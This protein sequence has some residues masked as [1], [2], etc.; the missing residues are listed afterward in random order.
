[1]IFVKK[2][3]PPKV[4]STEHV[5]SLTKK[6]VSFFHEPMTKRRQSRFD[7]GTV[8]PSKELKSYLAVEFNSKCVYCESH[9]DVTELGDHES[10]RPRR[11]AKGINSEFSEDHYWWLA[12]EWQN[13]YYSCHTCNASKQSFF[14][15]EGKRCRIQAPYKE[16]LEERNLLIDPCNEDPERS[17]KYNRDG[18][19][20]PLNERAKITIDI[21]KLNRKQLVSLRRTALAML[22][23]S[24]KDIKRSRGLI[25][26]ITNNPKSERPYL[27]ILR[28]YL[29]EK[30]L[31]SPIQTSLA[32]ELDTNIEER[33]NVI[34]ESIEVRNFKAIEHLKARIFN[35]VIEESVTPTKYP[36]LMLLG[37]NGVGKSTFLQALTLALSGQKYIDA[38]GKAPS[39]ILR[40]GCEYGYVKVF[41]YGDKEPIE[42]RF[43]RTNEKIIC[44]IPEPLTYVL[45][46]GSTRLPPIGAMKPETSDGKVHALNL[47]RHDIALADASQW[48][49]EKYKS[50]EKSP[51]DKK[52]F[53]WVG[54]SIK[55]LLELGNNEKL[56]VRDDK[57]VITY[58]GRNHSVSLED[59]SDGYKSV[60]SLTVDVVKTL[61]SGKT[62]IDTA[63]GVVIIDEI[64][65][66]LHPKWRMRIVQSLRNVFPL[67]Q[68]I[69]T[70]HDPLCL[71][72]LKKEEVAVLS[73]N[74]N[75]KIYIKT[76]LP[77]PNTM[78]IEQIL[79]SDFFSL[80][81]TLDPKTESQY[82]EYYLLLGKKTL[83]KSDKARL[84]QLTNLIQQKQTIGNSRYEQLMHKVV[85]EQIAEL[86]NKPLKASIGLETETVKK[87][88]NLLKKKL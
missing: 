36:W 9:I 45:A 69:V 65:T 84:E 43:S 71:R 19:A 81:N 7:F 37:E 57:V 29:R 80:S 8:M 48:I 26:D 47:F 70:T 63:K 16:V 12:Y 35:E 60:V 54:Q 49:V 14:P 64:G 24:L 2:L 32:K 53:D 52:L 62:T 17:I 86:K 56:D 22:I 44:S 73:K 18:M 88:K 10:F 25:E 13:I 38:L 83:T 72:G 68:F 11:N 74:R 51:E 55:D 15:V 40:Y 87:I 77:N 78:N 66:H 42:M 30:K 82:N 20:I 27:G 39:D 46:Y 59:L 50:G 75:H 41:L 61:L 76:D 23:L 58:K 31:A 1:M 4:F 6:A 5:E 21:I 3:S 79:G 33:I 34:V 28:W 85:H 67:V